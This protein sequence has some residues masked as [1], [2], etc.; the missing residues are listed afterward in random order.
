MQTSVSGIVAKEPTITTLSNGSRRAFILILVKDHLIHVP[1]IKIK[2]TPWHR[3]IAWGKTVDLVE[4]YLHKGMQVTLDCE[5]K[6]K[7][8]LI[9][10]HIRINYR[11]YVLNGF[12]VMVDFVPIHS[13]LKTK[14]TSRRA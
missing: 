6:M 8:D 10:D 13:K 7:E 1:G 14:E 11:E 2:S 5:V 9:E 3:V 12:S 4:R